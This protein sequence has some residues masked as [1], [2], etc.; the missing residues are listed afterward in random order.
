MRVHIGW[1]CA[2]PAAAAAAAAAATVAAAAA[3]AAAAV[4]GQQALTRDGV[5]LAQGAGRQELGA[6]GVV[7]RVLQ[8]KGR[9]AQPS[10]PKQC[11]APTTRCR[12]G[13]AEGHVGWPARRSW[14]TAV[15][16]PVNAPAH[17]ATHTVCSSQSGYGSAADLPKR[18]CMAGTG[19]HC[20]FPATLTHQI[21]RS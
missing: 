5:A 3:A 7:Q 19:T 6:V 16:H 2:P 11:W 13:G 18:A 9:V 4:G 10:Q 15:L 20:H 14:I 17:P 21:T 8:P 12:G 1:G